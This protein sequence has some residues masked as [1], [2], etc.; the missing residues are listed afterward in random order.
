MTVVC[1]HCDSRKHLS[2]PEYPWLNPRPLK[3]HRLDQCLSFRPAVRHIFWC[4]A[5]MTQLR[6]K[7]GWCQDSTGAAAAAT[8]SCQPAIVWVKAPASNT[9]E[10]PQLRKPDPTA[11]W[12][13]ICQSLHY[14]SNPVDV[15]LF[16]LSMNFLTK[17]LISQNL[18]R[19]HAYQ[20]KY[21]QKW[22]AA[23]VRTS[24]GTHDK[25]CSA[26]QRIQQPTVCLFVSSQNQQ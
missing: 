3:L 23:S 21:S 7:A 19:P 24:P 14:L 1:N 15:L 6:S 18:H 8:S 9:G 25:C 11:L 5:T 16:L 12:A 2:T 10:V 22:H 4:Q 17:S 20:R 13:I 26:N